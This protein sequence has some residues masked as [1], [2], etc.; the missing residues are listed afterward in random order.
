LLALLPKQHSLLRFKVITCIL[1][2][3]LTNARMPRKICQALLWGNHAALAW[4]SWA[5]ATWQAIPMHKSMRWLL[6]DQLLIGKSQRD[7]FLEEAK[8]DSSGGKGNRLM[9]TVNAYNIILH[10]V[11]D[12]PSATREWKQTINFSSV[13]NKCLTLKYQST[14]IALLVGKWVA[15]CRIGYSGV[16]Y[17]IHYY[18]LRSCLP[19]RI[20][21]RYFH[22]VLRVLSTLHSTTLQRKR[23]WVLYHTPVQ[24]WHS[25]FS[26]ITMYSEYCHYLVLPAVHWLCGRIG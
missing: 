12:Q 3:S 25:Q 13:D 21:S 23:T 16:L 1:Q 6:N 19:S 15:R 8:M 24:L 5:K 10:V 17:M 26:T 7:K 14:V 18:G 20:E 2:S 11:T 9:G 22:N 4:T